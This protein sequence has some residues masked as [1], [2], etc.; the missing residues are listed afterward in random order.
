MTRRNEKS[1]NFHEFLTLHRDQERRVKLNRFDFS[2]HLEESSQESNKQFQDD[3]DNEKSIE[4][5]RQRFAQERDQ[6]E[7]RVK[8]SEELVQF[9]RIRSVKRFV[10]QILKHHSRQ[11]SRRHELRSTIQNDNA[12]HSRNDHQ[13]VDQ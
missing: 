11:Q 3:R 6:C 1:A 7:K 9:V 2:R 5:Q 4:M 8:N 12:E 13:R 10:D